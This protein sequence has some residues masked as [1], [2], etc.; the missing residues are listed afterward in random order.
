MICFDVAPAFVRMDPISTLR[1]LLRSPVS[2]SVAA[3]TRE[4]IQGVYPALR[5]YKGYPETALCLRL[6]VLTACRP[7]AAAD[8]GWDELNDE[9]AV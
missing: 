8:A 3:T 6:I 5:G 2:E 1:G 7:G 4:Q 9:G